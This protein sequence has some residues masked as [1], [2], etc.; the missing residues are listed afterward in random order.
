MEFKTWK[1]KRIYAINR[2]LQK[3]STEASDDCYYYEEY[4]RVLLSNA[5]NK[6]EYKYVD[7]KRS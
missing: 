5:K 7:K 4:Q 3:Y 6:K 1:D 2:V